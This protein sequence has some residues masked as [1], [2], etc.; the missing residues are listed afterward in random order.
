MQL[1]SGSTLNLCNAGKTRIAQF[2]NRIRERLKLQLSARRNPRT[3]M[4]VIVGC[5]AVVGFFS[6]MTLLHFGMTSMALRYPVSIAAAYCVFLLLLR[7]WLWLHDPHSNTN[8]DLPEMDIVDLSGSSSS[9][10]NA[11]E[12]GFGFGGNGDFGGAG[13]G[14]N[15][16]ESVSSAAGSNSFL[17][18]LDFDLEELGFIILAVAAIIGG[19]LA[20]LY[21][22][23]IA[24]VLL[25]E[26][27]VDGIL[28]TGLYNRVK[29]IEQRHWLKTAVKKTL[30]PAVLV[31][32]LFSVAGYAMR[33]IAPQAHSIGE[34]WSDASSDK[35]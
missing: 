29:K 19:L 27:L 17:D 3:V 24:P 35:K 31:A 14:G 28:I 1:N 22:V 7:I 32:L 21:I 18:G 12:A 20:S 4:A 10:N 33:Q 15:W 23:Y 16:G 30:L 26:I 6:S 2:R 9:A 11:A 13:A 25:A 5:S 8:V 34:V